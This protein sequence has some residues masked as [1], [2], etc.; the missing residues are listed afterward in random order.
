MTIW[1]PAP[2]V[3]SQATGKLI[4]VINISKKHLS[5][6]E[7][8]T[9]AGAGPNLR[10]W[11]QEWARSD[12]QWNCPSCKVSITI[13]INHVVSCAMASFSGLLGVPAASGV[14]GSCSHLGSGSSSSGSRWSWGSQVMVPSTR[15]VIISLQVDVMMLA[16]CHSQLP[17][18]LH[19]GNGVRMSSP[20]LARMR[21]SVRTGII[22]VLGERSLSHLTG[23]IIKKKVVKKKEQIHF[24]RVSLRK[25]IFN[26]FCF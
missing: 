10:M 8:L 20:G 26:L 25:H 15:R 22:P 14:C 19:S 3:R 11:C 17:G 24:S 18:W 9:R 1:Q 16:S 6:S 7:K 12:Q 21:P 5:I 2:V 13:I 4:R 23:R